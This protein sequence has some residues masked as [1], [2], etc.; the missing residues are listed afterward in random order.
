MRLIL[1]IV[2]TGFLGMRLTARYIVHKSDRDQ[3]HTS[4]VQ[5]MFCT[6]INISM[7]WELLYVLKTFLKNNSSS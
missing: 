6:C 2:C 5:A 1:F 4:F 7:S 3:L